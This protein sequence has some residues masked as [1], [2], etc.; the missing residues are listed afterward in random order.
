MNNVHLHTYALSAPYELI[1]TLLTNHS[2]IK[3]STQIII[4][5]S[6]LFLKHIYLKYPQKKSIC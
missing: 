2:F 3:N 1:D 4:V 5:F 6:D